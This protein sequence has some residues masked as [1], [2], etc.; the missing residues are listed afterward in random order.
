MIYLMC[1]RLHVKCKKTFFPSHSAPSHRNHSKM[2]GGG[3]DEIWLFQEEGGKANNSWSSPNERTWEQSGQSVCWPVLECPTHSPSVLYSDVLITTAGR[4][5]GRKNLA[6]WSRWKRTNQV[7][8][9][10]W[11]RA[12]GSKWPLSHCLCLVGQGRQN[13]HHNKKHKQ[14]SIFAP[15]PFS[16]RN[17]HHTVLHILSSVQGHLRR[18]LVMLPT[19]S[20]TSQ[21]ILTAHRLYSFK[22]HSA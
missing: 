5:S 18:M 20:Q 15:R 9:V 2:A 1:D 10:L 19:S 6:H 13:G 16:E 7:R 11:L 17:R 21:N 3:G 14:H 12:T 4:G 22:H 8:I